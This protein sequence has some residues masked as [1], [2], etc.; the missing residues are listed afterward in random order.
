MVWKIREEGDPNIPK[1]TDA[2]DY[3]PNSEYY[4][5]RMHY[6]GMFLDFGKNLYVDGKIAHID[7]GHTDEMSL[8]ELNFMNAEIGLKN[9]VAFH[10]SRGGVNEC[11]DSYLIETDLD[12]LNMVTFV[13][14]N[15][16]V[17][18]FV[19]H[20]KLNTY[21]QSTCLDNP[22]QNFPT[23]NEPLQFVGDNYDSLEVG[24]G[25]GEE[26]KMHANVSNVC[27]GVDSNDN[28]EQ[29]LG[30]HSSVSDVFMDSEGDISDDD[31]IFDNN[32]LDVEW[33][34]L[35]MSKAKRMVFKNGVGSD[36]EQ[37][38]MMWSYAEEIRNSNPGTTVKIKCKLV[39]GIDGNNCMYPFAYAI[40]EKEKKILALVY[41]VAYPGFANKQPLSLDYHV[42]WGFEI[43]DV[44]ADG[45]F[46]VFED[47]R[48]IEKVLS[49]EPW[50]FNRSLLVLK[51]FEGLNSKDV[52]DIQY[53]R[54][55]VQIH[56]LPDV[57]MTNKI[58]CVVGD[59][60]VIEFHVDADSEGR[61]IGPYFRVRVLIDISKPLRRG[62]P[63]RLRL[64]GDCT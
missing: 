12:V 50:T 3:G 14:E 49:L 57:W 43:I 16:M 1:E 18:F 37:Y 35:H 17:G 25:G 36:S 30:S 34:G 40:V 48:E 42:E 46:F 55:W 24:V 28:D 54:F 5:I 45:F 41:G 26:Q 22:S 64:K 51:E 44:S 11:D 4:T 23:I 6:S 58:G 20:E 39:D 63:I 53:T 31:G 10:C 32:D 9:F 38:A 29:S 21:I 56:N 13:D 52:D 7:G 62:A 8:I 60:L 27:D 19:E 47:P 59:G 61:C 2:L 33:G 15:R